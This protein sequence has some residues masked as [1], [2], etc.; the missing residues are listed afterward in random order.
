MELELL[1][2][3]VDTA[4]RPGRVGVRFD[5]IT[6]VLHIEQRCDQLTDTGSVEILC[7]R[8]HRH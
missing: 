8:H 3:V 5:A 7:V 2:W 6:R 4:G 1:D